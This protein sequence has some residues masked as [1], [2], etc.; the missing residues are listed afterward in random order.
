MFTKFLYNTFI[1]LFLFSLLFDYLLFAQQIPKSRKCIMVFGAHAD[2]IEQIAGGTLAKYIDEGY[3]GVYV[4]VINNTAGC[5]IEKAPGLWDFDK[6]VFI[7]PVSLNTYPPDALE[8][9]QIRT[10]E[11]LQAAAVFVAVPVFL[12]FRELVIWQGRKKCLFGTEEYYDFNPPGRSAVSISTRLSEQI[13]VV[14]KL[15]GKYKPEIIITHTLGG[16]KHDH[17]NS[18]YLMYLAFIKARSMGIPVGKL[19]MKIDGWFL[20]PEALVNGRGKPDV[21]IEI[22]KYNKIKYKALNQHISQKGGKRGLDIR[23]GEKYY[24]EFITVVD[25]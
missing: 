16:E 7:H 5:L 9:I 20:E 14:V 2:D 22:T 24:E 10:E 23:P 18:A 13:N 15:L 11:A 21:K 8:T 3:E 17:G 19:W 6:K 25:N 4:V 1:V 12:N